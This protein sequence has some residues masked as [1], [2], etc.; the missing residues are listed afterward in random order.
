MANMQ[1]I[2]RMLP[3][4]T[5][6]KAATKEHQE[7]VKRAG[8]AMHHCCDQMTMEQ[9]QAHVQQEPSPQVQFQH[10]IPS[11]EAAHS[12]ITGP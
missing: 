9:M 4:T 5:P 8:L 12:E 7:K 11:Q 6:A 1:D 2:I 10:F 3:G